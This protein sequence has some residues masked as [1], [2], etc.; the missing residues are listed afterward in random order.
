MKLVPDIDDK[1]TCVVFYGDG[2]TEEQTDE[3]RDRLEEEFP[4]LDVEFIDGGQKHYRL[5][6]GLC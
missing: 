2:V 5:I 1:E 6:I 3:R 4:L